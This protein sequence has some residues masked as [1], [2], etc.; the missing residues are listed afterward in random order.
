M[1]FGTERSGDA[2]FVGQHILPGPGTHRRAELKGNLILT[3]WNAHGVQCRRYKIRESGVFSGKFLSSKDPI[4]NRLPDLK[5]P[6][7][8]ANGAEQKM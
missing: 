5:V 8:V 6:R 4:S 3:K 2:F 7:N 1:H